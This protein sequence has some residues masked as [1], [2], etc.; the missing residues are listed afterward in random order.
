[1]KQFFSSFRW[2][3][4]HLAAAT[5]FRRRLVAHVVLGRV[6][7][8][9]LVV[10]LVESGAFGAVLGVREGDLVDVYLEL[11]RQRL[12]QVDQGWVRPVRALDRLTRPDPRVCIVDQLLGSRALRVHLFSREHL[13]IDV[14]QVDRAD[15]KVILHLVKLAL[16]TLSISHLGVLSLFIR[17]DLFGKSI[18]IFSRVFTIL[19][20][21]LKD[22]LSKVAHFISVRA[23]LS[24]SVTANLEHSKDDLSRIADKLVHAVADTVNVFL[25]NIVL[26][27]LIP[28]LHLQNDRLVL[29]L[30]KGEH[31]HGIGSRAEDGALVSV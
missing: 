12:S 17:H 11:V 10:L 5:H 6:H 7:E 15:A 25:H 24:D 8:T 26:Q 31:V 4:A 27:W 14:F 20:D 3:P 30:F 1:M 9:L 19:L 28:S 22:D 23:R 13:F 16:L 29:A 21:R 2:F 18:V